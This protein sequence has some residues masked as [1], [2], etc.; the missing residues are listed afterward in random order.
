MKAI[1][2]DH[3]S[4][5]E[6]LSL[7]SDLADPTPAPGQVV[8]SVRAAGLNPIDWK[9]VTGE[10]SR[11]LTLPFPFVPGSDFSG[12]V[13]AVGEN[14]E[15]VQIGDSVYGMAGFNRN[16]SGSMA[17]LAR[18]ESRYVWRKP[19]NLTDL[20]AAAVP[21][22]GLRAWHVLNECLKVK[23]GEK[24]LIQG[25]AGGIGT[26][27]IQI[28]N[29]LGAEVFATTSH[30]DLHF[31]ETLGAATAI[32]YRDIDAYQQLPKMDAVLDN[33]G[34]DVL[35]GS[36]QMLNKGGRITSMLWERFP[37][38]V[39]ELSVNF[40]EQGESAT[41][42]SFEGMERLFREAKVRVFLDKTFSIQQAGPALMHLRDN[43]PRGKVAITLEDIA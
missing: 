39:S 34:G 9:M 14:V 38:S 26:F 23:P 17:Q 20:E 41:P 30:R 33:V 28:A 36:F 43:H 3:Y 19:T 27:A 1:A 22:A 32:D 42:A 25:G 40:I 6:Q 7:R 31:A 10:L 37:Q 5:L 18:T 16:G 29:A 4:E 8:V 12:I 35:K 15:H 13:V 21:M 24:L 11:F 2:I